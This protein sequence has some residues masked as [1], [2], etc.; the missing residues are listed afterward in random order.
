MSS[1]TSCER[2]RKANPVNMTDPAPTLPAPLGEQLDEL[3]QEEI[4]ED[5][6]HGGGRG[7]STGESDIDSLFESL[8]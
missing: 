2:F 6:P 1:L 4:C 3:H 7:G 5:E 8:L